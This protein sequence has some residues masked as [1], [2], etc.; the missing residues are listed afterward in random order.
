M[1]LRL[2]LMLQWK[3]SAQF[4]C[5]FASKHT[6]G[7]SSASVSYASQYLNCTAT[8]I[9]TAVAQCPNTAAGPDGV[10]FALPK[11]VSDVILLPLLTIFL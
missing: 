3:L 8:D 6:Q 10:S 1:M 4:A 9:R 11:A 2:L 5:N 7:S